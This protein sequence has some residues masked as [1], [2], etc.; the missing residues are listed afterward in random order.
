MIDPFVIDPFGALL[1]DQRREL[2]ILGD[3]TLR[4]D[5]LATPTG[6]TKNISGNQV[7]L[8]WDSASGTDFYVYK[9]TDSLAGPFTRIAINPPKPYIRSHVPGDLYMVRAVQLKF[10]GSGSYYNMSQGVIP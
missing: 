1:G 10:T 7:T 8:N 2:T 9:G 6:V 3:P 5:T 4:L